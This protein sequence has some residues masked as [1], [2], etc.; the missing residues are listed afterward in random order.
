MS[1]ELFLTNF[2]KDEVTRFKYFT[3]KLLDS[4]AL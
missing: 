1:K 4:H 2:Q 3:F